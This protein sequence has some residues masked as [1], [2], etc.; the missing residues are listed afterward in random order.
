[1]VGVGGGGSRL[2]VGVSGLS[3]P[4]RSQPAELRVHPCGDVGAGAARHS[5][6]VG[7]E[8]AVPSGDLSLRRS[9]PQDMC[10]SGGLFLRTCVPQEICFSGDLFLRRSVPQE[11]CPSGDLFLRRSVICLSGDLSP[12]QPFS[13]EDGG[14]SVACAR[15]RSRV[16]GATA[17][18]GACTTGIEEGG[19]CMCVCVWRGW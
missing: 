10:P 1:M 4:L 19:G 18:G 12:A 9:V 14:H 5:S 3:Q 17:S 8:R 13:R 16:R 11:I 6:L 2:F 15:T 7:T